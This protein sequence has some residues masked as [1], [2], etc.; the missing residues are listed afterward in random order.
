MDQRVQYLIKHAES[1]LKAIEDQWHSEGAAR[2]V[3]LFHTEEAKTDKARKAARWPW[4]WH[5]SYAHCFGAVYWLFGILG[6][7]G[8]AAA[9]AI[10]LC[11]I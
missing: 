8:A 11:I 10:S 1:A 6:I 5:L 4:H 3:L 7:V 2:A 9:V